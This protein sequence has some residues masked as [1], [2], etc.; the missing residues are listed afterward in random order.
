[1]RLLLLLLLSSIAYAQP[2]INTINLG[3]AAN[4]RT[5]DVLRTAGAKIN[6]NFTNL[7]R[8]VYTNAPINAKE[9]G[10]R[11]DGVTDDS[12]AL[13]TVLDSVVGKNIVILPPG[14]YKLNSSITLNVTRV[15]LFGYNA[16]LDFTGLPGTDTAITLTGDGGGLTA[17]YYQADGGMSGLEIE[18]PGAATTST[19]IYIHTATEPGPSHAK[20]ENC[21]IHRFKYGI[22]YGDNAYLVSYDN[23]DIHSNDIGVWMPAGT[24]NSGEAIR[25]MGGVIYNNVTY[26]IKQE[27]INGFIKLMSTSIDYNGGG[28]YLDQGRA[29]LIGA[30]FESNHQPHIYVPTNNPSGLA[31]INMSGGLLYRNVN[32][33]NPMVNLL[34]RV[35]LTITGA[36]I[37]DYATTNAA[38]IYGSPNSSVFIFGGRMIYNPAYPM[39][40]IQGNNTIACWDWNGGTFESAEIYS[41][42]SITAA[43]NIIATNQIVGGTVKSLGGGDFVSTIYTSGLYATNNIVGAGATFLNSTLQV[44]SNLTALANLTVSGTTASTGNISTD[45]RVTSNQAIFAN[46]N[47]TVTLS[48]TNTWYNLGVSAGSG[49]FV[50]RD[51]TAGNGAVVFN[52]VSAGPQYIHNGITGFEMQYDGGS[53]NMQ[54]RVTSGT[55]PRQLRWSLLQVTDQ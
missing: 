48:A 5:G 8:T 33:T 47:K 19:G 16:K 42:N 17:P 7:W 23:L 22:R 54:V 10:V 49:L 21:V 3:A 55:V 29:D 24:V 18:G 37:H 43:N 41:K 40:D 30:H 45:G 52:D 6:A 38:K 35:Q 51:Q 2:G 27:S 46:G 36:E 20:L 39:L 31:I 53:T 12:V 4:D 26:A 25:F 34:G 28:L 11:G 13:Q 14:T 44:S 1:M 32:S 50:L 15:K 9:F